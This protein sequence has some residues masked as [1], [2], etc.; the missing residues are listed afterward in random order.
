M[1]GP[2]ETRTAAPQK[3]AA[4]QSRYANSV[5]AEDL[6]E[7]VGSF[8]PIR[9][10]SRAV[11]MDARWRAYGE[12]LRAPA[13]L[14]ERLLTTCTR[15]VLN[16][17]KIHL[18]RVRAESARFDFDDAGPWAL[19]APIYEHGEIVDIAA[20]DVADDASRNT[21][22]V[23]HFAVGLESATW[24]AHYHPGRRLLVHATVWSWLRC[25]CAGVVPIDWKRFALHVKQEG[26]DLV[27]DNDLEGRKV[28][29][30]I[31]EALK[32]PQMFVRQEATAA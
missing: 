10:Y 24:D 1:H 20:F 12:T 23:G 25:E 14:R 22:G 13:E 16:D 2:P 5:Q 19:L 27:V 30:K 9:H 11:I 3:A 31:K 15:T 21:Y 18:A 7:A 29:K 6:P 28:E 17:A 32:A 26:F 8:K 4:Q